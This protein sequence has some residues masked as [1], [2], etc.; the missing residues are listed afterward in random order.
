MFLRVLDDVAAE[1]RRRHAADSILAVCHKT[2][3]GCM[4]QQRRAMLQLACRRPTGE[5]FNIILMYGVGCDGARIVA[6]ERELTSCCTSRAA[7]GGHGTEAAAAAAE[8]QSSRA[9]EEQS[10]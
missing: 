3:P 5:P 1:W 4:L 7:G 9:A 2:Q 10:S 6:A 8:E